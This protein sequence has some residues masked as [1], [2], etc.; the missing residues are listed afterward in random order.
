MKEYKRKYQAPV[1]S[2]HKLDNQ[3]SLIMMTWT[4]ENNPPDPGAPPAA[5]QS[6]NAFDENPFQEKQ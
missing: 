3:I 2:Q 1:I 6:P 5:A 4:D